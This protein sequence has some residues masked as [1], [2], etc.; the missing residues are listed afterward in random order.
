MP[1]RHDIDLP[2]RPKRGHLWFALL[3]VFGAVATLILVGVG[4]L[5][6]RLSSGPIPLPWLT[7]RIEKDLGKRLGPGYSVAL[8]ETAL[9]NSDTGPLLTIAGLTLRDPQ[10]RT[11]IEAPK[12]AVAVDAAALTTGSVAA[13]RL[14]F[15]DLDVRLAVKPDGAIV[16]SA[17]RDTAQG[18]QIVMPA[19]V[20]KDT[21]PPEPQTTPAGPPANAVAGLTAT[22]RALLDVATDPGNSLG[23]L[24]RLGISRGRFVF[25]D[26]ATGVETI[27]DGLDLGFDKLDASASLTASVHGPNGNW[28]FA[29]RT[30]G[31]KG[32]ERSLD[33]DIRDISFEEISLLAGVRGRPAEFDMPVSL[34]VSLGLDP[35]G[36]L[37]RAQAKFAFGAGYFKLADPDHE[38]MLIDEMT[39][40]LDWDV[41]NQVVVVSKAELFAGE[42]HLTVSGQMSPPVKAEDAWTVDLRAGPGMIGPERPGEKA[43]P[44]TEGVLLAHVQPQ[45]QKVTIDRFAF[46]GPDVGLVL[47]GESIRTD[48]GPTLALDMTLSRMPL[49]IF[50]RLWPSFLAPKTRAWFLHHVTAGDV[51]SG[52]MHLAYDAP[53]LADALSDRP[54][55]DGSLRFDFALTAGVIDIMPG[56]PPVTGLDGAGRITGRVAVF[57][58]QHGAFDLG[59]G[60][61]VALPELGFTIADMSL[62]PATAA[63]TAR[64]QSS[65][66]ALGSLLAR[67]ALKP[68]SVLPPEAADAKGAVEGQIALDVRLVKNIGPDDVSA[69]FSASA[70]GVSIENLI[71]AESLEA[72]A[73]TITGDKAG[74]RAK[75]EGRIMGASA[76]IEL[77]KPANGPG[78]AVITLSMDEAARG[79]LGLPSGAGLSG[80]VGVK[81]TAS[82]DQGDTT[83]AQVELDLTRAAIDGLLP[84]WSKPS[85]RPGKAAFTLKTG[86]VGTQLE[87]LT[88]DAGGVALRGGAEFDAKGKFTGAKFSQFRLS[89]GDEMR[90]EA[91]H[92][93]ETL[94]LTVRGTV[95]DARPFLQSFLGQSGDMQSLR[96]V[97]I[98]LKSA[99]VTGYNKQALSGADLRL[100]RRGGQTRA[101]QLNG[102]FGAD[103]ASV[104]LT[105]GAYA[106]AS[107]DAGAALS[108]FDLYRHMRGGRLAAEMRVLPDQRQEGTISIHDFTLRDEPAMRRLASEAVAP[109][110]AAAESGNV[111]AERAGAALKIDPA[112][113]PFTKLQANFSRSAGRTEITDGVMWGPQIGA[114]VSGFIDFARDRVDLNGAFIPAYQL[115]NFFAKIPI[116]GVILGGGAN[117][118]LF[119]VNYRV[120]GAASAPVLRVNPLSAIAPG[121]LRKIFGAI[122]GTSPPGQGAAGRPQTIER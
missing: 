26:E 58:A 56:L 87:Q 21:V 82:L 67:D 12:A 22:L 101:L 83:K 19:K 18:L 113:V 32:A 112:A 51:E 8:G 31:V 10:G 45:A 61:R 11:L 98:D 25:V 68:F 36:A 71:G 77:R 114:T 47:S 9:E 3:G 49:R 75:G 78:D 72:A 13:R 110:P 59:Q 122:D 119:A 29:S 106:I 46:S 14:E 15:Y 66:E 97:D 37:T 84:G 103:S 55:P 109:A 86:D 24:D 99:A 108:F 90:A 1:H 53:T 117:E 34:S 62:K 116:V 63:I 92:T 27:F 74:L 6:W 44:L 57:N 2:Q 30:T 105:G 39:G 43:I 16:I 120:A 96:D 89:P 42:T 40:A 79:K 7:Q 23:A 70:T 50:I 104:S 73:L 85:G 81:V 4:G 118:G 88:L 94:K 35:A 76:G 107:Q 65:L 52:V 69:K 20:R 91:V 95:I 102:R 33:I 64:F 28:S 41:A 121:F 54:L 38:P 48:A 93:G 111:S 17:G 80:P 60:R 115:N 5:A 100:Q